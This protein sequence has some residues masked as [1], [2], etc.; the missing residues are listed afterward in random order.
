[1]TLPPAATPLFARVLGPQFANLAPSVQRGHQP[2][3]LHG[4][5][6]GV[7]TTLAG[8]ATVRRGRNVLARLVC[9]VMDF[10]AAG[11][12]IPVRVH[13][14]A[15][16]DGERWQ[17]QFAGHRFASQMS[18][19]RGAQQGLLVE[20]FG[21]LRCGIALRVADGALFWTVCAGKLWCVPVPAWLLPTGNSR[22]F[23]AEGR[24]HFDVDIAHPLLGRIV[25]YQ[26]WLEPVD[27]E[28]ALP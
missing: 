6:H 1:M 24:F 27:T 23:E 4:R 5:P 20:Q 12:G 10:P 18:A 13:M 22:E 2:G 8:Q 19:G 16:A 11:D 9:R 3:F 17:R 26:G 25:H 28:Q 15:E 14:Q 7:A 21:P